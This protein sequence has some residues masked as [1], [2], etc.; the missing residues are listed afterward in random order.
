MRD[1][2]VARHLSRATRGRREPARAT[3]AHAGICLP[4]TDALSNMQPGGCI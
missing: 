4:F 2:C 3:P 1:A